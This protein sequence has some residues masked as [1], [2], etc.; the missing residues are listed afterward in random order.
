[1]FLKFGIVFFLVREQLKTPLLWASTYRQKSNGVRFKTALPR[2]CRV[3]FLLT[4]P[5]TGIDTLQMTFVARIRRVEKNQ[6]GS[7]I[8]QGQH[9]VSW[10]T[11]T[12]MSYLLKYCYY[13]TCIWRA[14]LPSPVWVGAVPIKRT[15]QFLGHLLFECSSRLVR[16]RHRGR[17]VH[18]VGSSFVFTAG[19]TSGLPGIHDDT[20]WHCIV[21]AGLTL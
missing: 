2:C 17:P 13:I 7:R 9:S 21:A 18:G 20:S 14:F 19:R 4:G 1:M 15:P 16:Y 8:R 11:H 6:R 3:R 12:Y 10:S 5:N